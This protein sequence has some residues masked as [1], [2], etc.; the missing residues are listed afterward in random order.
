[1]STVPSTDLHVTWVLDRL[2]AGLPA[3]VA[4]YDGEVPD[5][6]G[7]TY[8]VLY[9]DPGSTDR[10]SLQAVSDTFDQ[11]VQPT[12]VGTSATQAR[13]VLDA[14]R[15]ALVDQMPVVAG[16]TCWPVIEVPG[17]PPMQRD[18][19]TRDPVIDRPRFF[20]T[21]QFRVRSTV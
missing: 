16:R 1:M 7:Q 2:K 15:R 21:P 12:C 10:S 6:P 14:V 11:I 3:G 19:K 5:T 13:G 17:T 4:V 8:V 20:F 9:P 18:P